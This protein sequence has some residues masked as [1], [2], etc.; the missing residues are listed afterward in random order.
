M[1]KSVF[2]PLMSFSLIIS[3]AGCMLYFNE[4]F[5]I[6]KEKRVDVSG[7]RLEKELPMRIP[8]AR[9][10][11]LFRPPPPVPGLVGI[12]NATKKLTD[13]LQN[14]KFRKET[15]KYPIPPSLVDESNV[16]DQIERVA[17]HFI[18]DDELL[19]E[20]KRF[21][22]VSPTVTARLLA[23]YNALSVYERPSRDIRDLKIRVRDLLLDNSDV[24]YFEI[25][26]T[27]E[28]ALSAFPTVAHTL[29]GLVE[30]MEISKEEK[31][32]YYS[33]FLNRE[34]TDQISEYDHIDRQKNVHLALDKLKKQGLNDS[35]I[36]SV[37]EMLISV[38][39]RDPVKR[40]QA[41]MMSKS[42]FPNYFDTPIDER[43]P[44]ME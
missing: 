35:Q 25:M 9:P 31:I 15:L 43:S 10:L 11:R 3:M 14:S 24:A 8:H 19:M 7:F 20:M 38:N 13:Q 44:S 36:N 28:D 4:Q 2:S 22:A 37:V 32:A 26:M 41:V 30:K 29:Q 12:A 33:R 5:K 27:F 6:Q 34:L 23:I 1:T 39:S 40:H 21:S 18:K 16:I 42:Y 17:S